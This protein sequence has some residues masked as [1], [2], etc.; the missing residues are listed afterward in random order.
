MI[1]VSLLVTTRFAVCGP[2]ALQHVARCLGVRVGLKK[3]ATL[4]GTDR[5]GT[6]LLGLKRAA[7]ALGLEGQMLKTNYPGLVILPKPLIAH[8]RCGH[9]EVVQSCQESSVSMG[10]F[11]RRRRRQSAFTKEWSGVV[12]VLYR[13]FIKEE[14]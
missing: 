2:L 11:L 6:T 3:I 1:P 4:A 9:Y 13:N 10:V 8:M 14:L 5:N 12:L 7:V